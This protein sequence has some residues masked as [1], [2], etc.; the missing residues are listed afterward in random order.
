MSSDFRLLRPIGAL[1]SFC[2]TTGES[3]FR[4]Q[5]APLSVK[6]PKSKRSSSLLFRGDLGEFSASCSGVN[7]VKMCSQAIQ[8]W[9]VSS[10]LRLSPSQKPHSS[11]PLCFLSFYSPADGFVSTTASLTRIFHVPRCFYGFQLVSDENLTSPARTRTSFSVYES[12]TSLS[13]A[14]LI[15]C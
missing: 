12:P 1:L 14:R 11:I 6:K 13:D 7:E 15:Q 2:W 9:S 8:D 10:S 4:D 3:T 5:E